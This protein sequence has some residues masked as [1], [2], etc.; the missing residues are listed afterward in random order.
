MNSQDIIKASKVE[1]MKHLTSKKSRSQVQSHA[2]TLQ[3]KRMESIKLMTTG[4]KQGKLPPI[5]S[6]KQLDV[7]V[8]G[9][10]KS[11]H[12]S[13]ASTHRNK[14]QGRVTVEHVVAH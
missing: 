6:P 13:K 7:F 9:E 11:G 3:A 14:N 10:K 12:T 8:F 1:L 2:Q 5:K 4:I